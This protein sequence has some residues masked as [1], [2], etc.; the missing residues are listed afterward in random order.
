[1]HAGVNP[2]DFCHA[3]SNGRGNFATTAPSPRF[4]RTLSREVGLRG[5]T[6]QRT[7]SR[8]DG[9]DVTHLECCGGHDT[10]NGHF[11]ELGNDPTQFRLSSMRRRIKY[12]RL[13]DSEATTFNDK[14]QEPFKILQSKTSEAR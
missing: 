4:S 8:H 14:F 12:L 5:G 13:H 2:L 6:H 10:L 7:Y 11:G 9:R 1:M 3:S